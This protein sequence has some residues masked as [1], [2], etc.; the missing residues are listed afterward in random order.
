MELIRNFIGVDRF[1]L[2]DGVLFILINQD[3]H[4]SIKRIEECTGEIKWSK[5]ISNIY[6]FAVLEEKIV[7][8]TGKEPQKTVVLASSSG[9]IL[10][11]NFKAVLHLPLFH[12]DNERFICFATYEGENTSLRFTSDLNKLEII[13]PE[14]VK[15]SRLLG[16]SH[17]LSI[18][19]ELVQAYDFETSN[20]IWMQD[21]SE[22]ITINYAPPVKVKLKIRLV[23]LY[24]NIIIV[25]LSDLRN[26]E[27]YLVGIS[28]QN[29]HIKWH[30]QG[31]SNFELHNGKL[32]NI[33]FYGQYRILNPETGEIEQ[34]EDLRDEFE[35]VDINCEHRFNV[36]D[37]HIYFK[38][39]I[40]G[41]FGI[42]NTATL[43]IE[44][45]RQLPEGNTMSTEEYPIPFGNRL[46]VRS[47]PQ[48]NLFVYE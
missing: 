46:Y 6:D 12:S 39:A 21:F 40:K 13:N 10:D 32:Y 17:F 18:Q 31:Y 9:D 41:K 3:T 35:R 27:S 11:D 43:E 30:H 36:T 42:L 2:S 48:N 5:E 44:E 29:G 33:E 23:E 26:Q 4:S 7:A 28:L 34:E 24:E 15:V 16:E 22:V 38:H 25:G 8:T 14:N 20:K 37:T 19:K 47:A 45:V 1:Y